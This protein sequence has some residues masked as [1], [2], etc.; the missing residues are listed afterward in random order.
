MKS[1][2]RKILLFL[3]NAISVTQSNVTINF[4]PP[5]TTSKLQP[6]D[7]GI[8]RAFK[9][10]YRKHMLK[11]VITKIDNFTDNTSLTKEINVLDAV[12]WIDKS[13]S[14]TKESTIA[15]CFRNAGFPIVNPD[16]NIDSDN[17]EDPD[18]DIPLSEL[19]GMVR[20]CS[21]HDDITFDEML[22][23]EAAM[24]TETGKKLW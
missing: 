22:A 15:S 21:G 4:F 19:M 1:K 9:A 20:Q 23:I 17:E 14:D 10:R 2:K 16:E 12:Y 6:L 5:N 7:L 3:D 18:D 24:P 13:W 11:H 8:I